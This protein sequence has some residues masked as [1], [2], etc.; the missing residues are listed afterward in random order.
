ML[1]ADF[2]ILDKKFIW[3]NEKRNHN[4]N[5]LVCNMPYLSFSEDMWFCLII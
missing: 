1:A 5:I 4:T 3:D 2:H